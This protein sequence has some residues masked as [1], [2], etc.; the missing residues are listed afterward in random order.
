MPKK[1]VYTAIKC[2]FWM[3]ARVHACQRALEFKSVIKNL[4]KSFS[5]PLSLQRTR[6]RTPTDNLALDT[7]FLLTLPL[8]FLLWYFNCFCC[9]LL[10]LQHLLLF[11]FKLHSKLQ[12]LF[13]LC[14]EL[15]N[16]VVVFC[17]C[18]SNG[19]CSATFF[20]CAHKHR[21]HAYIYLQTYRIKGCEYF[22]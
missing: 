21:A 14:F 11:S 12:F 18:R 20:I 2:A 3:H 22:M 4:V 8:L 9:C 7:F 5:K 15:V 13:C 19:N 10:S 17:F 1:Y 16:I 6:F